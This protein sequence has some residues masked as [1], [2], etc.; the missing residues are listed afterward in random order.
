MTESPLRIA[1]AGSPNS[2][3]TALFNRLTGSRQKVANYAGVTVD[4]KEGRLTTPLG[5]QVR[6]LDLPG[7][8]S[9]D[10]TSID[11]GIT[12]AIL[13]GAHPK[14]PS[15][16]RIIFVM[17]ATNM[18]LH[19]RLLLAIRALHVPM[20]VALTMTDRAQRLGITI[21]VPR[22]SRRLGMPVVTASPLRRHG[23]RQLL[24][25]LDLEHTTPTPHQ[26]CLDIHATANSI[27]ADT[28]SPLAVTDT[29]DDKIDRWALH[30]VV[31]P[32]LLAL[33]LFL[34]FQAVYALGKPI[35]D[36]I[37]RSMQWLGNTLTSPLSDGPLTQ[38]LQDGIFGGLGTL[39]GFLPQLLILFACIA[40]LESSGYLPRA[41][42]LLDKLMLSVG[43]NGRAF[44]PLLSS[45]ACA[46]PSI[47]SARSIPNHRDR[48]VTM[49]IAPLM[50]CSARLPVYALLIGA[51]IPDQQVMGIFNVQGIV[52]FLLYAAGILAAITIAYLS[53]CLTRRS[54]DTALLMELPAYRL[55]H[56]PD[57]ALELWGKACLFLRRLTGV[58]L[59]LTILMW[60]ICRFPDP[61]AHGTLSAIEYSF[62]GML[63]HWLAPL[64]SPLGFD[65]RLTVALIPAFAAREVTVSTLATLYSVSAGHEE[66]L[67]TVLAT[68]TSMAT[69]LALMVWFAFAPQCMSTLAVIKRETSSWKMVTLSFTYMLTLAYVCT[70]ATYHIARQYL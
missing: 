61:P 25:Q 29:L 36:L 4:Y 27:M 10:A 15:P 52:L 51:F 39:L 11:E 24:A 5:R 56:W 70:W 14:E 50:T 42:F 20:M 9:I 65:W 21:D 47:I 35:T 60:F 40:I 55:P 59:A 28:V 58:M 18:R 8:Y 57:I 34:T 22:L 63:G 12:V 41:A 44:I 16:E 17:D 53:K 45:F 13:S 54:H 19:L 43:L 49:L 7:T 69:A 37:A 64:F 2:G 32:C 67:L 6:I 66:G 62:A 30:P 33:V 1:L 26:P 23:A 46:I 3:K 48:L 38:L 31:G 68:Q